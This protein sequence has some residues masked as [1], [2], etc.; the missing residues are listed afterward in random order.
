MELLRGRATVVTVEKAPS[1]G[2]KEGTV[3]E[4][5]IDTISGAENAEAGPPRDDSQL[6]D[7]RCMEELRDTRTS[8]ATDA[9]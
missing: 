6:E 3:D 2:L 7:E 4:T 8:T 5:R 9:S 1:G